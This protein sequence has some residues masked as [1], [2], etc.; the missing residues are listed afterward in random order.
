MKDIGDLFTKYGSDKNT[1]HAYGPFYQNLFSDP[2]QV[3]LVM[4]IGIASGA[5]LLA[6]HEFYENAH[7]VGF[8][9]EPCHRLEVGSEDANIFPLT[10]RPDRLEIHQG[11][12]RV[13]EDLV[14]AAN[15]RQFDLVVEDALHQI[16]ENL[17]CLLWMWRF[18]K[19][20]GYYV[21][22]EMDDV[23]QHAETCLSLFRGAEVWESG[24]DHPGELLLIVR[25]PL[26]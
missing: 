12:M 13:R 23:Q 24:G 9:K 18:V 26:E 21:I 17:T 11:D 2:L 6:Y 20:G 16:R 15:H 7:V 22:E 3:R 5:G 4:E 1:H 10:P 14:R 19:P 25:K 8:D